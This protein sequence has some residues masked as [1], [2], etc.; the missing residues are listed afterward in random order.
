MGMGSL[1]LIFLTMGGCMV[2]G[3]GGIVVGL[4]GFGIGMGAS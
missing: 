3:G 1:T 2:G 4:G